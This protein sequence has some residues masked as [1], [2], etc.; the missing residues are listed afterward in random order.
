MVLENC[1]TIIRPNMKENGKTVSGMVS[2]NI[3]IKMTLSFQSG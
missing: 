1:L 2:G 3:L